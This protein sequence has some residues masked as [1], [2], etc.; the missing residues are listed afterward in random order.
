MTE[1]NSSPNCQYS[2][3]STYNGT[4]FLGNN[5][6]VPATSVSN[7]YVVPNYGSIGYD[8][9]TSKQPSCSGFRTITSAYGTKDVDYVKKPCNQ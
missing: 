9:L 5:P 2:T 4:S 8:A 6:P 7:I 1:Y 3:L